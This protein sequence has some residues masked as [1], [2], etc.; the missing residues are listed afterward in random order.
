MAVAIAIARMS[1]VIEIQT[2]DKNL[3][4]KKIGVEKIGMWR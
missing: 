2:L 3:I 4:R 1:I